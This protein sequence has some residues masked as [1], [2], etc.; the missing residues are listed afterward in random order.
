M[1]V[2]ITA[3]RDAVIL[4]G[5][6]EPVAGFERML[7]GLLEHFRSGRPLARADVETALFSLRG[8]EEEAVE[9]HLADA[10][11]VTDRGKPIRARTPGQRRYLEAI[12]RHDLT[13]GVGPAG[14]GKT[15]LAMA[16]AV[17]AFRAKAVSRIILCRPAVEAGEKL[18]FLP[19]DLQAKIDPYLRPLYDALYDM[20]DA[21]RVQRHLE[22]N[23]IEV[24]PLAFMRGRTLNDSF[25]I[26]DEAQNTTAEQMR[27]FLTRFGFGSKAVVTGDDTQTDLPRGTVG[28]LRQAMRVLSEVEGVAVTRLTAG[29]VVRHELVQRIVEAYG[30]LDSAA[31]A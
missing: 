26:L 23:V 30:R 7:S 27:M 19:G 29:D 31:E 25:I 5:E 6:P 13:F 2:T 3:T 16:C 21:E 10:V 15:Y 12:S 20:M 24:A 9:R 22:R 18:G 28:G 1:P 4:A 14:T 11:L 17:K 8:G